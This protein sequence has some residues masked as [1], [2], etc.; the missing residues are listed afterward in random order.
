MSNQQEKNDRLGEISAKTGK[1]LEALRKDAKNDF[2]DFKSIAEKFRQLGDVVKV[3]WFGGI[4]YTN[5]IGITKHFKDKSAFYDWALAN[6]C[7]RES[8]KQCFWSRYVAPLS[9]EEAEKNDLEIAENATGVLVTAYSLWIETYGNDPERWPLP[10]CQPTN[11][12]EWV[13]QLSAES[14]RLNYQ[15]KRPPEFSS[16]DDK[17]IKNFAVYRWVNLWLSGWSPEDVV[18]DLILADEFPETEP[19]YELA[20]ILRRQNANAN[21]TNLQYYLTV[22]KANTGKI[23]PVKRQDGLYDFCVVGVCCSF[24]GSE[25]IHADGLFEDCPG[26]FQGAINGAYWTC[27]NC[28]LEVGDNGEAGPIDAG[29]IYNGEWKKRFGSDPDKW[30]F[31]LPTMSW[32]EWSHKARKEIQRIGY[33]F[34]NETYPEYI[35]PTYYYYLQDWL[36]ETTPEEAVLRYVNEKGECPPFPF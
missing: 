36:N 22:K 26:V 24:C 20:E 2:P 12:M 7:L 23:K 15:Y 29:T 31:P 14:V 17:A 6:Y 27:A 8:L 18:R 10:P 9:A 25:E 28:S 13:K 1:A 35:T 33:V 19:P 30:P 16:F 11:W 32:A 3:G 21:N 5:I 34:L 4:T